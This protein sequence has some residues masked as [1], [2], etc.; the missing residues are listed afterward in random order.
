MVR[1]LV[2][3]PNIEVLKTWSAVHRCDEDFED[4]TFGVKVDVVTVSITSAKGRH[5]R[6]ELH[7]SANDVPQIRV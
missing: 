3:P 2:Q 6:V 1:S 7:F 4:E 5:H